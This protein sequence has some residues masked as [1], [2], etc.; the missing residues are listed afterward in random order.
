M[1][2]PVTVRRAQAV[3]LTPQWFSAADATVLKPNRG[4]FQSWSTIKHSPGLYLWR[5]NQKNNFHMWRQVRVH[6]NTHGNIPAQKSKHVSVP[7][8]TCNDNLRAEEQDQIKH[9]YLNHVHKHECVVHTFCY[10]R[11]NPSGH[12]S[13]CYFTPSLF[14]YHVSSSQSPAA[15]TT[16]RT[17]RDV[18]DVTR[19]D[20]Q[21]AFHQTST[22][23]VRLIHSL[24]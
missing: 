8:N 1:W 24:C 3:A 23:Q 7:A 22:F 15:K 16:R 21:T 17:G 18:T 19:G 5:N 12:P 9:S 4:W 20:W 10:C 13:P 2:K 14:T 6:T 11:P